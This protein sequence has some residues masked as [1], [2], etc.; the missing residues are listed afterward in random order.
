MRDYSLE[1]ARMQLES[2]LLAA[3]HKFELE[4][5]QRI[6]QGLQQIMR[7]AIR[8]LNAPMVLLCTDIR[9]MNRSE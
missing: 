6:N 4:E 7:E 1:I 2:G 5:H 8:E 9:S 3:T